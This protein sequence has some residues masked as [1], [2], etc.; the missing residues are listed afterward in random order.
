MNSINKKVVVN[1][2]IV[3]FVGFCVLMFVAFV[4]VV[5]WL[6]GSVKT[7]PERF[8]KIE[9]GMS[10][11]QDVLESEGTPDISETD[12]ELGRLLY[13]SGETY[14]FDN[15]WEKDG[16]VVLTQENVFSDFDL[17]GYLQKYGTPEATFFDGNME[18]AKW[19][20]YLTKGVAFE[21]NSARVF[22]LVKFTPQTK[23]VF[24]NNIAPIIKAREQ[25]I[26]D[27]RE[28]LDAP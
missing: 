11:K 2:K 3:L 7:A 9:P 20:V 14:Y 19:Y 6:L 8:K 13:K 12:Q 28:F 18:E 1:K 10:T 16:K 4:W 27:V 24:L 25:E 17:T 22:T 23:E 15:V 26:K 21:A 5:F